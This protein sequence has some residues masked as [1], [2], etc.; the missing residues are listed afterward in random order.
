MPPLTWISL[1]TLGTFMFLEP[2]TTLLKMTL[3]RDNQSFMCLK[4]TDNAA[5]MLFRQFQMIFQMKTPLSLECLVLLSERAYHLHLL[6]T[7]IWP[8][9]MATPQQICL[10]AKLTR[11]PVHQGGSGFLHVWCMWLSSSPFSLCYL[12]LP[13]TPQGKINEVTSI[14]QNMYFDNKHVIVF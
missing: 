12:E 10:A 9:M 8:S 11:W 3:P 2:G 5:W 1:M 4:S 14:V 6:V 13:I 7:N